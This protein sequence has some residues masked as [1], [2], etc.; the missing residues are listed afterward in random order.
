MTNHLEKIIPKIWLE[1]TYQGKSMGDCDC[2]CACPSPSVQRSFADA[3]QSARS[4]VT[5]SKIERL[6]V[7]SAIYS[8]K[9]AEN[10]LIV[11]ASGAMPLLLNREASRLLEYLPSKLPV[12]RE[13]FTAWPA[14]AFDGVVGVLLAAQIIPSPQA[15]LEKLAP[16]PENDLLTAWLHLTDACNLRCDYCYVA[17]RGRTMHADI[18][19][20]SVDAAYRA[21]LRYGFKAVKLKYAGGEPTLNFS[22]LEVA[23]ERAKTLSL[24][25]GIPFESVLLTNG[26]SISDE[27]IEWLRRE[28]IGVAISLD[29]LGG[30]H[31]KQRHSASGGA[32]FQDVAQTL[33]RLQQRGLVPHVSITITR[34]SLPGL[35]ELV[36]YLLARQ[37]RFSLNFYREPSLPHPD[38][39]A[40][41]PQETIEGLRRAFRLIERNLPP[42]SL[43]SALA[44]RADLSRPHLHV[45]GT[46]RNY[47]AIDCA[48]NIST[49]QM[50]MNAPISS[51]D[52]AD[53]LGDLR[54]DRSGIQNI[55]VDEKECKTCFWR[56][57]CAGG[58]PRAA[59][60]AG[61]HDAKSPLCEIY[62]NIFPDIL[63]LEALR[64]LKYEQP[65]YL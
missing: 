42:Y 34:R 23:Q 40:S 56:Y 19:Q 32:S 26:V 18:A 6:D 30:Y 45:C 3:I 17:R 38:A 16:E 10:T 53:P 24:R 65:Y 13:Q 58:C 44:D 36:E 55:S 14:H 50:E 64:L 8:Q 29:G 37:L 15:P 11:H 46:G 21:A 49:C 52:A 22:A 60:L 51:L 20:K 62:Q 61:R 1:S 41:H 4:K 12:L 7:A 39:L 28:K 54:N 47:M 59:F 9:I 27:R 2:D 63:H 35:P 5:Q 31:D 57:R 43:L 33:D 48:G 25:M